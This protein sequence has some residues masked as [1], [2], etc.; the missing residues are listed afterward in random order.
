[1]KTNQLVFCFALLFSVLTGFL[2]FVVSQRVQSIERDIRTVDK[3][4]DNEKESLRVLT[5][6]WYYLNRPDRLEKVILDAQESLKMSKVRPLD[7]SIFMSENVLDNRVIPHPQ[8]KP[9]YVTHKKKET[10]VFQYNKKEKSFG[11]LLNGL[12]MGN[13][14]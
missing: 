13:G 2:L 1:M 11:D 3:L 10:P 9:L 6:E 4:V 8:M 7:G 12:E 14:E 5:A